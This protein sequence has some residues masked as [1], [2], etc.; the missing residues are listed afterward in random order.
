MRMRRLTK[1]AIRDIVEAI[2]GEAPATFTEEVLRRISATTFAHR[3][4][5]TQTLQQHKEDFSLLLQRMA[6]RYTALLA[7][8]RECCYYTREISSNYSL[9]TRQT[10]FIHHVR[11]LIQ[12]PC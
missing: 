1:C 3:V 7:E 4:A 9:L 11:I 10:I 6:G 5:F 2:S 12:L 8:K